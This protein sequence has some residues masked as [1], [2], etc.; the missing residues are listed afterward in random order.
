ML[1]FNFIDQFFY[2]A[3]YLNFITELWGSGSAAGS[4]RLPLL[5]VLLSSLIFIEAINFIFFSNLIKKG[6]KTV[7]S[8]V[9]LGAAAK[10]GSDLYDLGKE[11]VKDLIDKNT[12]DTTVALPDPS[13]NE[14][15][16]NSNGK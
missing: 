9:V 14:S 11:A 13:N 2:L 6:I 12:K 1:T 15:K 16:K 5:F 7:A 10:A 8:G 4:A 3:A